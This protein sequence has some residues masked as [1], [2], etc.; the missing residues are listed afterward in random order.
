MFLAL[1]A[2]LSVLSVSSKE[3][4]A[5][6]MQAIITV[7]QLPPRESFSRRVSF[8]SLR[9][10]TSIM[11]NHACVAMAMAM[12][13]MRVGEVW[14]PIGDEIPFVALLTQ[15]VDAVAQRQQGPARE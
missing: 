9:A 14:S 3:D 12:W 6:L 1:L 13:V 15:R 10:M 5:E 8:E 2:Y 7:R 4:S 11:S